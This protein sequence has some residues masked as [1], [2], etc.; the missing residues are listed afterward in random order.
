MLTFDILL[1]YG[2]IHAEMNILGIKYYR[3]GKFKPA[4]DGPLIPT[5]GDESPVPHA[6]IVLTL[7]KRSIDN[8]A[9]TFNASSPPAINGCG[10][11]TIR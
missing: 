5:V 11:A 10:K 6:A 3:T 2:I 4:V 8:P 1:S 9:K 7:D